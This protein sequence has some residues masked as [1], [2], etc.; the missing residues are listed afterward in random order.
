M[1]LIILAVLLFTM[2][3]AFADCVCRC[4]NGEVQAICSSAIDLEPIC[5]PRICSIVPPSV[6]PIQAPR[7]PPIG[8]TNCRK[9]QVYNEYTRRYEWKTLCS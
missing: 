1:R 8:T 6:R 4:V 7:V 9:E 2:P 5:P 3:I